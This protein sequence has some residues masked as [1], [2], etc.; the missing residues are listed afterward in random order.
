[1]RK[2]TTH[3]KDHFESFQ[4]LC[5]C[6]DHMHKFRYLSIVDA[7]CRLVDRECRACETWICLRESVQPVRLPDLQK[8]KHDSLYVQIEINLLRID[9]IGMGNS[10]NEFV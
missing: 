1:M 3:G 10:D 9:R 7:Y 4:L 8:R 5:L 6:V 2:R